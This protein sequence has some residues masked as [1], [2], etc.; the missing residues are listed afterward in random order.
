MS[1]KTFVDDKK[2]VL[3]TA[4]L[5]K[6]PTQWTIFSSEVL[7]RHIRYC[8]ENYLIY[9]NLLMRVRIFYLDA[10]ILMTWREIYIY[11]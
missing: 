6:T 1:I 11:I 10:Y 3:L 2:G 7:T 8:H 4:Q 9:R 5:R